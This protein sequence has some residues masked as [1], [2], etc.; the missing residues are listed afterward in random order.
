MPGAASKKQYAPRLPP[1]QRRQQLL[2]SALAVIGADG[3]AGVS[4]EAI[5]RTAGVTKPVVY[6]TFGDLGTLLRG[7]LERQ[8][9][10]ALSQVNEALPDQAAMDPDEFVVAGLTAFLETVGAHPTTWRLILMPAEGTPDLVRD[11]VEAGRESV[12]ERIEELLGRGLQARGG[13]GD[14]DVE[15]ASQCLLAIGEHLGRLILTRPQLY[16]PE[17]IAT[18]A[19]SLLG[20]LERPDG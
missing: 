19:A 8:E 2:D 12:R 18:F 1:A 20:A 14:V 11:H 17:R 9:A 3:Y 15:L 13:P 7:L 16:S 10:L 6:D 4:M 5:A